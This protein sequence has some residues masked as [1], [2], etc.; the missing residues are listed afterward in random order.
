MFML[1][2]IMI[3]AKRENLIKATQSYEH[4]VSLIFKDKM[5]APITLLLFWITQG[6]PSRASPYFFVQKNISLLVIETMLKRDME[7]RPFYFFVRQFVCNLKIPLRNSVITPFKV[8][9]ISIAGCRIFCSWIEAEPLNKSIL[10][11]I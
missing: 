2:K 5:H 3:L 1:L 4:I 7:F 6:S 11:S 9:N 8:L 10:L